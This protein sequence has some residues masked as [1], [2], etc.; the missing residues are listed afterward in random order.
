MK[1]GIFC[2]LILLLPLTI[3]SQQRE[4][5]GK[6]DGVSESAQ[7]SV[8][9]EDENR[10]PLAGANIFV[11]DT[12]DG[13]ATDETGKVTI[14]LLKKI[15]LLRISYLGFENQEIILDVLG[16]GRLRVRLKEE[17]QR[18]DEVIVSS[19]SADENVKSTDLGRQVM[20]IQTIESLP[21][22]VGEVDVLKSITLLPGVTTV[23]EASSG[24]NIRGSSSDQ[25]LILL[26]GATLYNPSHLFGFFSAFNADLIQDITI[27]KGGIPAK[28]GGRAASILD[29][30]YK[31]GNPD[32]WA[33]KASLGLVS[34]K[35]SAGGP[36]IDNKLTLLVGGRTSYSNWLLNSIK[37]ADI[38]NSSAQFYDANVLLDYDLSE[39]TILQYRFYRSFDDFS[40]ASDTSFSW[41][42][43]NHVIELGH[44]LN[45]K[46]YVNFQ[47]A[48]GTYEFS[49]L[50]DFELTG[51]DLTSR[52]LDRNLQLGLNYNLNDRNK[53]NIGVQNKW[54]EIE[55]GNLRKSSEESSTSPITI[56]HENATES[57]VYLQHDIDIGKV[58]GITYGVRYNHYRFL[59]PNVIPD[60]EPNFP[61]SQVTVTSEKIYGNGEEINHF[62]GWE[63]RFAMRVSLGNS[64]SIKL[65]FNRMN[66]YIHL[67]SN[68]TTIAPT[69]TWK[70]SDP[71]LQPQQVTQYSGGIF[72]NFKDNSIETSIEVFY[73][74]LDNIL[75][76]KDGAQLLLNDYLSADLLN[77]FGRSYGLE[78][79]FQKKTG[80]LTGWVS[81]TWSKS[82]RKVIGA[83][84]EETIN[85]GEW[86]PANYDIPNSLSVVGEYKISPFV[87]FSS[88]FT[89]N[90]GRPVTY[91]AA[92]FVYNGQDIAYYDQRNN[93]RAPNYHRLDA[94][95]T[96]SF[97][98]K[99]KLLQ[100]DWVLSVYNIY[101]RKNA[102]SVFFDDLPNNPPQAYKL[103]VLGVAFPSISYNFD[104]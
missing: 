76:Y 50:D 39:N 10:N 21:P 64:A 96:F 25:N 92:K 72:K 69:D 18:L 43:Q 73:K 75:D 37:N 9:V 102:F 89:Y 93:F 104:F 40:F 58:L 44:A 49:I 91:P 54:L 24:F 99:Q 17:L 20:S 41:A 11:V 42:N 65:G 86:Y 61:R 19:R 57:S 26:G 82:E 79:Y 67:I 100:G 87:K 29:L 55:P 97:K 85:N 51:F 94:S 6:D 88:I 78:F 33:G 46:M 30:K 22:F 45:D 15:W 70:L 63:P 1:T 90:T 53:I 7:V 4:T 80:R 8:L 66:Q 2:I 13:Y 3:F 12:E 84:P 36:I 56:R 98:S 32:L 60:Y 48:L 28:Y 81:Y 68:T 101:N 95:L 5:V 38:K 77:G 71:Y 31:R 103:S 62:S 23:G 27:F 35:V 47:G 16:K 59:G 14:N 34:A 52:I 83:Y 74:D